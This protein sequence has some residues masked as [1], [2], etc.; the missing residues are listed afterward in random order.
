M[1]FQLAQNAVALGVAVKVFKISHFGIIQV[2]HRSRIAVLTEP[3]A[4]GRFTRMTKRR[5]TDVVREAGGLHNRSEM[6]FVNVLG[7][8]LFNQ[9]I[10]RN[11]KAAPHARHFDAVSQAT[12]HMVIH[13]ERVHLS[14]AAKAPE[15]CR[16]N[17]TVVIAV[18]VRTVRV[19]IGGV[20]VARRR[21]QS[22]PLKHT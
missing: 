11:R 22:I 8:I 6:V 20:P 16:K 13:R 17:N 4:N 2:T 21:K 3:F 18:K 7:Q 9:M 10:H 14:L 12:V 15:R 1:V 19:Q 5:V